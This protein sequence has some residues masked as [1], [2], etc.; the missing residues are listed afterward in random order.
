M[1][2]IDSV[3]AKM[4]TVGEIFLKLDSVLDIFLEI[5]D[6][7]QKS[8]LMVSTQHLRNFEH[9]LSPL[10]GTSFARCPYGDVFFPDFVTCANFQT[11][12]A[13][14]SKPR[15]DTD[16]MFSLKVAQDHTLHFR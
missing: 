1:V 16:T 7:K 3:S 12:E 13:T 6:L 8:L 11:C 15:T 10:W 5:L 2:R 9:L 14:F 4:K